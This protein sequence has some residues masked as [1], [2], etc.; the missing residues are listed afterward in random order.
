MKS[1][2]YH[3]RFQ[4]MQLGGN[5]IVKAISKEAAWKALQKKWPNLVPLEKC[6]VVEVEDRD[7]VIY[8]DNGDY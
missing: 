2:L 3:F 5:A 1:K 7:G 8:F 6:T 4:A